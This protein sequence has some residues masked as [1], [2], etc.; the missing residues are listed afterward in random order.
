MKVYWSP[1]AGRDVDEIWDYIAQDNIDAADRLAETF[2]AAAARL[3]DFPRMGRSGR[4]S[5][6][7]ELVIP[8]T[9]YIL[10]HRV[11]RGTVQIIRVLH[12]KREWPS[13]A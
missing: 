12:A 3:A 10:I 9:S 4:V 11:L 5:R 7:R 8:G 1:A 6:T 13:K 2:R